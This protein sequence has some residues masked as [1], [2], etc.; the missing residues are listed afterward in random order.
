[1]QDR[2][3]KPETHRSE[4]AV[5]NWSFDEAFKVLVFLGLKY[6]G[7]NVVRD[8]ESNLVAQKKKIVVVGDVTTIYKAIAPAGTLE[9]TDKWMASKTVIDTSVAGTTDITLTWADGNTNFD[10]QAVDL[11]A[12]TYS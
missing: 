9:A 11:T 10:N 8:V 1:M 5:Q 3:N 6:D 4:Q 12:L 2:Q 7:T